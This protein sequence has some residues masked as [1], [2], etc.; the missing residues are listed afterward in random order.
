[1]LNIYICEDDDAQR[2]YFEHVIKNYLMMQEM[3]SYYKFSTSDPHSLLL[4]LSK[5]KGTGLYFLDIDLQSDLDG[6]Q[7][8]SQIRKYDPRGYIVFITTHDEMLPQTFAY[9]VEAMDFIIK[10][11]PNDIPNKIVQCIQAASNSETAL[12]TQ[13]NQTLSCKVNNTIFQIKQ[14]DIVMIESDTT[15]HKLVIHTIHGV[16]R[17]SG[18]LKALQA[19]LSPCFCR[20][21]NSAVVNISHVLKY[22]PEKRTL[23]LD[24]GDTCPVSFR[25]SRSVQNALRNSNQH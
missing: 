21:H 5:T 20:C 3:D 7:L 22:L 17:I 12:H 4:E 11:Y 19:S 10:D 16:R 14:N 9:K 15:S 1:M 18:S 13:N 6:I 8:A 23:Y 24:N 25:M 2:I